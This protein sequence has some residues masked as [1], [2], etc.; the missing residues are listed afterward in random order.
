LVTRQ[1]VVRSFIL[2]SLNESVINRMNCCG[3]PI[4]LVTYVQVKLSDLATC[5]PASSVRLELSEDSATKGN[6][7]NPFMPR[8][9]SSKMQNDGVVLVADQDAAGSG[10]HFTK[11]RR[12]SVW[13]MCALNFFLGCFF[14]L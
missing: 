1:G 5:C 14:R 6:D 2:H 8:K 3:H 12:V 7:G 10:D 9:N 11:I 4:D 13:F